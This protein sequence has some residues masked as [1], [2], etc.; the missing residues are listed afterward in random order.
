MVTIYGSTIDG[1]FTSGTSLV[2][3]Y[4]YGTQVWPSEESWK[5][6]WP[7]PEVHPGDYYISWTPTDLSGVFSIEGRNYYLE[8][9]SGYFDDFSGVITQNAFTSQS[10]MLTMETTARK[11]EYRAFAGC[12]YLRQANMPHCSMVGTSAF[13]ACLNLSSVSLPECTWISNS[14]FYSCT[15]LSRIYLPNVEYI[16]KGAFRD[17]FE[18]RGIVLGPFCSMVDDYAFYR[19]G[20]R[21]SYYPGIELQ[22]QGDGLVAFGSNVIST[23]FNR[24]VCPAWKMPDYVNAGWVKGGWLDP[25]HGTIDYTRYI[26][27]GSYY[28]RSIGNNGISS[29]QIPSSIYSTISYFETDATAVYSFSNCST[30]VSASMSQVLLVYSWGL[31]GC[32]KLKEIFAPKIMSIQSSGFKSCSSLEYINLPVCS[33]IGTSAFYGCSALSYIMLGSVSCKLQSNAFSGCTSL[34][35]IYVMSSR[36]S[37]YKSD[38]Y[39]SEYSDI[40]IGY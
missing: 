23:Y 7:G 9:Y 4:T 8:S 24:L 22:Y 1:G 17:C 30:L 28:S 11:I 36:V 35:A 39:W 33:S 32:S 20:L 10:G 13:H 34:N 31:Y 16:G 15:Q 5:G 12:S 2:A 18:G 29:G 14:A 25:E 38:S 40:I 27:C 26:S 6:S 3:I 21:V 19:F 37:Y